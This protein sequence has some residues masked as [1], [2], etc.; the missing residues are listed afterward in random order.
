MRDYTGCYSHSH[1]FYF[2]EVGKDRCCEGVNLS[3]LSH[4]DL[5]H[6]PR[7]RAGERGGGIEKVINGIGPEARSVAFGCRGFDGGVSKK[8]ETDPYND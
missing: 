8:G 6:L 7:L 1:G 4:L 3:H 5:P 2:R